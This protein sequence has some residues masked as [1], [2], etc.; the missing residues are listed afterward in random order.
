MGKPGVSGRG[1]EPQVQSPSCKE[2]TKAIIY[3]YATKQLSDNENVHHGQTKKGFRYHTQ[4]NLTHD[5]W[6]VG[7]SPEPAIWWVTKVKLAGHQ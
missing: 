5:K 7:A 6:V 1:N 3:L 4:R 2:R